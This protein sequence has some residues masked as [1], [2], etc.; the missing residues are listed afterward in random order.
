MVYNDLTTSHKSFLTWYVEKQESL[1]GVQNL[2]KHHCNREF[3]FYVLNTIKL[4]L[5]KGMWIHSFMQQEC[6][7][8]HHMPATI[9]GA[10]ETSVN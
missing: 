7:E 5:S 4:P 10:K 6:T 2:E 9:L 1:K 8:P 3:I